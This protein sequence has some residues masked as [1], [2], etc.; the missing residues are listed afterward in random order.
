[1]L[2]CLPLGDDGQ[3]QQKIDNKSYETFFVPV[4]LTVEPTFKLSVQRHHGLV[5]INEKRNNINES[6]EIF[7]VPVIILILSYL[8]L[9]KYSSERN[10]DS[11]EGV[12]G[13]RS[14][15]TGNCTLPVLLNV[16]RRVGDEAMKCHSLALPKTYVY[17][18]HGCTLA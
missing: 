3:C 2:G 13:V 10:H 7:L 17:I 6:Y 8:S 5:N 16:E 1:M 4:P 11:A 9:Q 18:N 15:C 14:Y 12:C